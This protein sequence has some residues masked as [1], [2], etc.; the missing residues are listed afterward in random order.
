MHDVHD[1]HGLFAYASNY[2]ILTY[3]IF[4][5]CKIEYEEQV[6]RVLVLFLLAFIGRER[7]VAESEGMK[8]SSIIQKYT[9]Y[10]GI[11]DRILNSK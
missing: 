8:E 9:R 10:V 7:L 11:S 5:S 6:R 3:T 4:E 1:E 2:L